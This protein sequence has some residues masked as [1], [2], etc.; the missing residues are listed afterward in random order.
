M[1]KTDPTHASRESLAVLI[2][3]LHAAE[4]TRDEKHLELAEGQLRKRATEAAL[5]AVR[6]KIAMVKN[7]RPDEPPRPK[8]AYLPPAMQGMGGQYWDIRANQDA[9]WAE[10]EPAP[11]AAELA[12]LPPLRQMEDAEADANSADYAA[13]FKIG[14]LQAQ[15]D[16]AT[17]AVTKANNAIDAEIEQIVC[18]E[19]TP[20]IEKARMAQAEY[21]RYRVVLR[22]LADRFRNRFG[23]DIGP[24][25]DATLFLDRAFSTEDWNWPSHPAAMMWREAVDKLQTDATASLPQAK[26]I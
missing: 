17:K 12:A 25:A 22:F 15:L 6:K 9:D 7:Y 18:P 8:A 21:V 13:N 11:T 24:V 14:A 16:D 3:Q 20:L 1:A 19:I 26:W 5:N 10:A 2:E 23:K 4:R